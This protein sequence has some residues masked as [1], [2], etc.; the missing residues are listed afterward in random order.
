MGN[1]L[2]RTPRLTLLAL[3]GAVLAVAAEANPGARVEDPEFMTFDS[4]TRAVQLTVIARYDGS[5]GGFNFNG[6]FGGG[7]RITVPVGWSVRMGFINR[8]VIEHSVAVVKDEGFPPIRIGRPAVPG[9]ASRSLAA[10]IAP[11]G[12]DDDI[13]F[14]A[15]RVG[16]YLLACGV[17]GHAAVG[18]YLQFVVSS[19]A[20]LPTYSTTRV[21]ARSPTT[22]GGPHAH[23]RGPQG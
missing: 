16:A 1:M 22:P 6:G 3:A 2:A 19:D 18:H 17:P 14:A 15:Q 4:T 12:R 11:G 23:R 8:D 21:I 20:R 13:A 5:N 10:G 7:H 9:A